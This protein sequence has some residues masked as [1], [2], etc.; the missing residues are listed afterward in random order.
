MFVDVSL[1]DKQ[2]KAY[3]ALTNNKTKFIVFGGGANGGKS[4]LGCFWLISQALRYPGTKYFIG[5][6]EL[7]K[8]RDTTYITFIKV[9]KALGVLDLWEY[10]SQDHF[11]EFTN[12]SRID[13]IDLKYLPRDPLFERY[14]STEYTAGW[15][16]EGGEVNF[17]AFD[18]L[19]SRINRHLNDKYKIDGKILITCNPKKNWLYKHFY[20]PFKN[21]ELAEDRAFIQSLITDNIFRQKGS[22]EMLESI[23]NE[24]LKQRL[25]YG[26]W[27]YD[28]EPDQLIKYI[29]IERNN[30][31]I[32]GKSYLGVDVARYGNDLSV[33]AKLSGNY[34]EYIRSF[35]HLDSTEMAEQVKNV[36]LEDRTDSENVGIDTVGLGG[37][38]YDI[39]R[40]DG[41]V[42]YEVQSGESPQQEYKGYKFK[43]LRALMWWVARDLIKSGELDLTGAPDQ[44]LEDL[45]APRYSIKDDKYITVE[46]KKDI[47][48]RIGRSTDFGDAFVYVVWMRY[49][50]ENTAPISYTFGNRRTWS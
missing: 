17:G 37:G 44:L 14:G 41:I 30:R 26:N 20:K 29:W 3:A 23:E 39:L 6:D 27:E 38:V 50:R 1:Y 18:V 9:S 28:E 46:K 31:R 19:K 11:I 34:L 13:L 5:R 49:M 36:I 45:T 48:R 43:N 25:R 8:L 7:K 40:K 47:K 10:K 21:G 24:A 12:G 16:E 22:L 32:R 42:C 35:K 4:Y 15:I 2:Y 33:I